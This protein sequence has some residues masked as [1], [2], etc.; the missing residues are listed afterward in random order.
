ML[1]RLVANQ[2][3]QRSERDYT[4]ILAAI[5]FDIIDQA[6]GLA[7][8][9]P[10]NNALPFLATTDTSAH[11]L[12]LAHIL[13]CTHQAIIQFSHQFSTTKLAMI[14]E[15]CEGWHRKQLNQL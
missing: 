8:A 1:D 15:P 4:D 5:L 14:K 12:P 7:R 11:I 10:A 13:S 3:S 9:S 2:G 6:P